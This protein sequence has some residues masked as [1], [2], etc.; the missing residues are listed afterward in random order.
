MLNYFFNIEDSE[1]N[2]KLFNNLN[3]SN[4]DKIIYQG[5]YPVIY[6]SLKDIKVNNWIECFEEVKNC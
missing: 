1:N 3:I 6:I 2:R 5:E 4:T